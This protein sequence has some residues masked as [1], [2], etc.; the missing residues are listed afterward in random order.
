M[1]QDSNALSLSCAFYFTRSWSD[2]DKIIS[3]SYGNMHS[4]KSMMLYGGWTPLQDACFWRRELYNSA[5]GL[6][7]RIKH[8]ADYD[9]FLRMSIKGR[10]EYAPI[11]FSA[12]RKHEGQ[13]SI[14][15]RKEYKRERHLCRAMASNSCHLF[16]QPHMFKILVL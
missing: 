1:S 15:G 3:H 12:F 4:L 2:E 10:C 8:A 16:W 14:Q 5:G 9:L 13:K 11:V 6:D 7:E